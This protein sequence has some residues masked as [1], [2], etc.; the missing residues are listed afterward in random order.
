M[1]VWGGSEACT[2][3][4]SIRRPGAATAAAILTDSLSAQSV[5]GPSVQAANSKEQDDCHFV[6]SK[7][8]V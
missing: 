2:P 8:G 4:D 6:A 3:I 5:S 7:G 1:E